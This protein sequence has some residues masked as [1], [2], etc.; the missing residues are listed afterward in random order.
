MKGG[1]KWKRIEARPRG[2][3]IARRRWFGLCRGSRILGATG[4]QGQD[5]RRGARD[6][7]LHDLRLPIPK[8]YGVYGK[9]AANPGL[10]AGEQ[11]GFLAKANAA[12]GH[13]LQ[14]ASRSTRRVA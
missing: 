7:R 6:H 13:S 4:R 10:S 12:L 2:A 9:A 5:L 8:V 14:N 3:E 11:N 1:T